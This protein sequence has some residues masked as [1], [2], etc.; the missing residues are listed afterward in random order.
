MPHTL[1][2][3][4]AIFLFF[5]IKEAWFSHP[6]SVNKRLLTLPEVMWVP[7]C[8]IVSCIIYFPD[9]MTVL[10]LRQLAYQT[11]SQLF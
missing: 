4:V 6:Y 2:L 9:K 3:L 1:C 8:T 7:L 5:K 10:F 11:L